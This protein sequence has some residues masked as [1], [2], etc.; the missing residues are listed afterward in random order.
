MGERNF[1][2]KKAMSDLVPAKLIKWSSKGDPGCLLGCPE[3]GVVVVGFSKVK[4]KSSVKFEFDRNSVTFLETGDYIIFLKYSIKAHGSIGIR[5][6]DP[7][8]VVSLESR[9]IKREGSLK[10]KGH[11][12]K[13]SKVEI[14]L[15]DVVGAVKKIDIKG[16]I[17]AV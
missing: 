17:V 6:I 11:F 13:G 8:G 14:V 16:S 10:M 15:L 1:R 9:P 7:H 4:V 3:K 2:P 5:V 12:K